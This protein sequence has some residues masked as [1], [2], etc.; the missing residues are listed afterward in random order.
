[1]AASVTFGRAA[2][3][4]DMAQSVPMT[5]VIAALVHISSWAAGLSSFFSYRY[6][7]KYVQMYTGEQLYEE[8]KPAGI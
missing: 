1:M 8:Y 7:Y 5:G 2:G 3:Q 4:G 6:T